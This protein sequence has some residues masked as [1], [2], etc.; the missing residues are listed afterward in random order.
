MYLY[1]PGFGHVIGCCDLSAVLFALIVM[2]DSPWKRRFLHGNFK[3]SCTVASFSMNKMI[4]I[5]KTLNIWYIYLH[6][7]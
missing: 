6:L 1:I 2:F 7:P 3:K 4:S 5:A